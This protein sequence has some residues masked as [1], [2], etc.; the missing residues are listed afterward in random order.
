MREALDYMVQAFGIHPRSVLVVG[1]NRGQERDD[2]LALDA[3][4][5]VFVEPIPHIFET[6]VGRIADHNHFKAVQAVLS[7]VA[8]QVVDFHV[9]SNIDSSSMLKLGLHKQMHPEVTHA[10]TIRLVTRTVDDIACETGIDFN[11]LFMD[12]QGAELKVLHGARRTLDRLDAV[13][14]EVSHQA[15]YEDAVTFTELISFM[16]AHDFWLAWSKVG[17]KLYGDALFVKLPRPEHGR[18]DETGVNVAL[19]KLACQSSLSPYSSQNDAQGGVNGLRTGGF[20]FH[21]EREQNP[22]W[23]VDLGAALAIDRIVVFNRLGPGSLRAR[24]LK[25]FSKEENQAWRLVHDQ[26]GRWF[27]GVDGKQLVVSCGGRTMRFVRLELDAL[28]SLHL[29]EIEIYAAAA[30]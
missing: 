21:T 30:A 20:G 4:E 10:E 6:L 1:A 24:N 15:L 13:Y 19:N 2:L 26:G 11:I 16:N 22:W 8:G 12:V 29:D 5:A 14:T 23:Q 27:G 7:D 17:P 3:C 18:S 25:I 28:N 9:T